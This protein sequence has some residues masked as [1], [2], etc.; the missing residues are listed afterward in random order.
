M[1]RRKLT[2]TCLSACICVITFAQ[3]HN[4][5]NAS[6]AL[7][8]ENYSDAKKYIDEAFLNESTSNDPKMW[9]YRSQIYLQI[10]L[11]Q[12]D[13]DEAAVLKATEAHLKCLQTDKK[14]RVI[15]RKWTSK[16]DVLS[17]TVNC[18]YKLFNKAIEE[19]NAGQYKSSLILY[20]AI[21][22]IIPLD[23]E[24]QLKRG[25]ITKETILYNSF[26]S[27]SKMKDNAN[28]KIILQQL[29]DIN[30]NEP[31]IYIHMSNIYLEEEDFESA[32]KYLALGRD[33]F[34]DDQALITEEINLYI[35]LEKT[36]E[37][38]NKLSD[39]INLD[40]EN[41]NYYVM[42]ATCHQNSENLATA[43]LDYKK[44]LEIN[45]DNLAA[46]NNI[47]ACYLEQ[48]EPLVVKLNNLNYNQN[49]LHDKYKSEIKEIHLLALP[50]L[51]HFIKLE[52]ADIPILTVLSEIYYKLEM[53]QNSK[54]IKKVIAD[55]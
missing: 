25:N 47:S 43:I 34:E 4:I 53:Y 33:M 35:R 48:T 13:L 27:S 24:D 21:F 51:E 54:D 3:K 28:S 8:N 6:I 45:P 32:F 2:L 49:S 26:F 19:Y 30:F 38:I 44:A 11:K 37:L 20:S 50:N 55:L 17:G 52:P 22:D 42:R 46:L 23:S 41:D 5:V 10:A 16:E 31:A 36:E 40:S 9:N 29:I 14:G 15:V 12:A 18:G 1:M 7:R 39:A